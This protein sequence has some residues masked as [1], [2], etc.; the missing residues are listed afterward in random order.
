MT[1]SISMAS[2]MQIAQQA[3]A[4]ITT[5]LNKLPQTQKITNVENELVYQKIDV[6]LVWTTKKSCY[7]VEIKGDQWHK[8]GNFFFETKS[9]RER[10]TPGCFLYTEADLLFYYFVIPKILYILIMPETRHWFLANIQRFKERSTTTPVGNG[11]YTTVGKL[12]PIEI[13]LQ[14][15]EVKRYNLDIPK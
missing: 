2:G 14:E 12:V 9:N 13:V 10:A 4:D 6:D 8:T 3:T 5:W 11:F 15:L 7:K 1:R